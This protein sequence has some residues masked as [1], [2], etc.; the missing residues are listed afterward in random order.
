MSSVVSD[1]NQAVSSSVSKTLC[2]IK[3]ILSMPL[4]FAANGTTG[5]EKDIHPSNINAVLCRF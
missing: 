4:M 3:Q 5:T 1:Q 2:E